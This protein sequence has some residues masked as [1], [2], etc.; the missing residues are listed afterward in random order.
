MVDIAGSCS[1]PPFSGGK[2]MSMQGKDITIHQKYTIGVI[3]PPIVERNSKDRLF[4]YIFHNDRASLLQLYNALNGSDYTDTDQ[5]QIVTLDGVLYMTM[6]NDLAFVLAHY[7]NMYEQQTSRNPNLPLRFLLYIAQEYQKFIDS[8]EA[9]LYG[10]RLIQLPTPKCVV[11]YNGTQNTEDDYVLSLSEAFIS[12]GN[13][14]DLELK[15]RVLNINKGHNDTL[16]RKCKRLGE[17]SLFVAKINEGLEQG[18]GSQQAIEIAIT[19]CIDHNIMSD[20]LS[21]NRSEVLGMLLMEYD[22]QKTMDYLRKEALEE[23]LEI[24]TLNAIRNLMVSMSLSADHAMKALMLS[25]EEMIHYKDLL[26]NSG[27]PI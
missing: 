7:L 27:D 10:S 2:S 15:V 23:G 21:A 18:I 22:E 6:K 1:T 11:F 20:I 16:M 3:E 25:E 24:S 17:Y 8:S 26:Q 14:S 4:R 9:N 12:K 5:L 19:Y 13:E